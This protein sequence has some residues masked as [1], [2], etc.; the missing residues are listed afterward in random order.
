M[1]RPVEDKCDVFGAEDGILQE[2]HIPVVIVAIGA[3]QVHHISTACEH[4]IQ[5][6]FH[7][8]SEAPSENACKLIRHEALEVLEQDLHGSREVT[9]SI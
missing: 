9:V 5:R 8:F 7:G 4:L 1:E 3:A 2:R 6:H